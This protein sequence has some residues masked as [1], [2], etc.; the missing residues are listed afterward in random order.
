MHEAVENIDMRLR[1]TEAAAYITI[2]TTPNNPFVMA[3]KAA[4]Q[5]HFEIC[6]AA[7]QAGTPPHER[8]LIG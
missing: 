4:A 5:E 3:G 6:T 1:H 2:E 8:K 7:R